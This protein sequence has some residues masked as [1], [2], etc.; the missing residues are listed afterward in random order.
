MSPESNSSWWESNDPSGVPDYLKPYIGLPSEGSGR[1]TEPNRRRPDILLGWAVGPEG[2]GHPVG[3]TLGELES[4]VLIVGGTGFGKTIAAKKLCLEFRRRGL[5]C[6]VF[7]VKGEYTRLPGATVLKPGEGLCLSPPRP[8]VLERAASDSFIASTVDMLVYAISRSSPGGDDASLSY[9]MEDILFRAV[10][11]IVLDGKPLSELIRELW[12]VP[13]PQVSKRALSS[14]LRSLYM[15]P[16]SLALRCSGGLELGSGKLIVADLSEFWRYS[17]RQLIAASTLLLS[18]IRLSAAKRAASS[19]A[20]QPDTIVIVDE[21]PTLAPPRSP[22][23]SLLAELARTIRSGRV[24]LAI[25][26]Q[27]F[28]GLR[29]DLRSSIG[30]LIA[31][32][33]TDSGEARA[34]AESIGPGIDTTEIQ[35]LDKFH[36]ILGG[37]SVKEPVF[38]V[39]D[40]D[41]VIAAEKR[42]AIESLKERILELIRKEPCL[43]AR[44][45]R[46]RLGVNGNYYSLAVE[47]LIREG[48]ISVVNL[49][50]GWGRPITLYEILPRRGPGVL[51]KC[52]AERIYN[53]LRQ[54]LK[55]VEVKVEYRGADI[56]LVKGDLRIAIEV[57]TG[58]NIVRGKYLNLLE[59][60]GFNH[61]IVLV[62]SKQ[63]KRLEKVAEG[64][65]IE[66]VDFKRAP[67]VLLNVVRE[68]LST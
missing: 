31:F 24:S 68:L 59:E 19:R 25:V 16:L 37:S 20:S 26:S 15:E 40:R 63:R 14:R 7:D 46:A 62:D 28:R 60:R 64:L 12:S 4:H 66:I 8:E 11:R 36:F 27:T 2:K 57:E 51:H 50:W 58:S 67:K 52:I 65:P 41:S 23:E 17:H 43:P 49:K 33:V 9:A 38:G 45:R 44:E 3:L 22:S 48:K 53:L 32:G 1:A 55:G 5:S 10:E 39:V 18:H 56:A 13:G 61:I 47:S 21:A 35:G 29:G 30:S 34:I 6:L 54:S 42:N